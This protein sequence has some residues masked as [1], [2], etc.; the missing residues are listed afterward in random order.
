[1]EELDAEM[2]DYFSTTNENA[3]PAEGNA[4]ANGAAPQQPAAN[5]G[6]DLGMAEI[7]V[8]FVNELLYEPELINYL[9][10]IPSNI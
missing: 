2:V 1:M 7:S 3:G 6:E 10:N 4:Q 9:V 8:S 5:G